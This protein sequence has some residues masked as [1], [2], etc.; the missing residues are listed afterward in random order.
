MTADQK[1]EII[2]S[3][4]RIAVD[5]LVI[6][7]KGLLSQSDP[8][9]EVDFRNCWLKELQKHNTIFPTGWYDPPPSG[10]I[11]LFG[12]EDDVTRVYEPSARVEA[13][14]PQ[15]TRFLDREKG[16]ALVYASPV[17][18]TTGIIGDFSMTLYF[19]RDRAVHD[20]LKKCIALDQEIFNRVEMGM[21]LSDVAKITLEL[22][23]KNSFKNII[24]AVNDPTGTNVGHTIPFSYEDMNAEEQKLF[25]RGDFSQIKDMISKKRKFVNLQEN[26]KVRPGMAFTI[27]PR[28][29]AIDN[30]KLPMTSFHTI[31]LIHENGDKELLMDFD[32]AK[33][34]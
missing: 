26:M 17:D 27:E 7:L 11:V 28:P 22:I 29:V 1:L 9:S 2:K 3:T 15:R 30:P 24:V 14:W 33:S 6:T 20:H 5:I 18:R 16:I 12:T 32:K 19:G 13:A 34:I 8:I 23:E 31:C 10:I 25:Q 21:K 4:R